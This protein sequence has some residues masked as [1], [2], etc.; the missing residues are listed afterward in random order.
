MPD[1]YS[2]DRSAQP[3]RP[4]IIRLRRHSS[5][6]GF[7]KFLLLLACFGLLVL[8][9]LACATVL[10]ALGY[11]QVT[12]RILPGVRV[13][14]MDLGGMT[15]AE[16]TTILD[17]TWN[18]D[19]RILV[20][21]GSQTQSL[22]PAQLGITLDSQLAAQ[23]AFDYAHNGTLL[24]RLVQTVASLKGGR[25]VEA[26]IN[27]DPQTARLALESLVPQMSQPARD[28]SLRL[29]GTRLVAVRPELG[30]TINVEE[31]LQTL[32]S[33]PQDVL[34]KGTLPVIPKPVLPALTDITPA[35][36]SAQQL[37]D[38]P[39][40]INIYDPVTD[41][42]E[43]IPVPRDQLASWI[44]IGPGEPAPRWYWIR[45]ASPISSPACKASL[46]GTV[47]SKRTASA[48]RWPNHCETVRLSG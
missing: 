1:A 46:E 44:K 17:K 13:G 29:E 5:E 32:L 28:A 37:V 41:Q 11:Y 10:G 6:A 19:T 15:Q 30:Y 20:T 42:R 9:A 2:S 43:S 3:V 34:A 18:I 16:A 31:T 14:T 35:L 8:F 40:S 48:P 27:T 7:P 26:A 12:G 39:A 22:S 33:A 25:Q 4:V 45:Q 23:K 36:V 47:I 24:D 21:N 38:R